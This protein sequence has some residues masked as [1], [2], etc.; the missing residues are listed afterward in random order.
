MFQNISSNSENGIFISGA[1]ESWIENVSI[2]NSGFTLERWTNYSGG[3]RDY[4]PGCQGMIE[5]R[6]SPIFAEF[7]EKLQLE[8][9]KFLVS[10]SMKTDFESSLHINAFNVRETVFKD[11]M[12]DEL[13]EESGRVFKFDFR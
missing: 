4:R 8:E 13:Q 6:S 2:K 11:L 10:P 9:T 1:P 5:G 12:L 3:K 7:V